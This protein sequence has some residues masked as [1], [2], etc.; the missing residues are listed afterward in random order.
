VVDVRDNTKIADIFRHGSFTQASRVTRLSARG[1][2]G[3]GRIF[4]AMRLYF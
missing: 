1:L 4:D 2:G 3:L